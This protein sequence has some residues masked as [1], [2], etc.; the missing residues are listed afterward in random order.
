MMVELNE[1]GSLECCPSC[2]SDLMVE[3]EDEWTDDQGETHTYL[4]CCCCEHEWEAHNE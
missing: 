4:F 1:D 3:K 2:T